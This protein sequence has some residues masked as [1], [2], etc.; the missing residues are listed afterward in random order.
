M[1]KRIASITASVT[2]SLLASIVALTVTPTAEAQCRPGSWL[3]AQAQVQV[4]V[5][6]SGSVYIGPTVVPPPP[7]P[8]VVYIQP[9]QPQPPVVIYQP[10]PQPQVVYQPQPQ[11]V[12]VQQQPQVSLQ[13]LPP[14]Q[15]REPRWGVHGELGAMMSNRISMGGGAVAFRMRPSPWFAVDLGIGTYG[16]IDYD[17]N[18]RFEI[19]IT[20]NALF[21][22]NPQSR[23]QLYFLAGVGLSYAHVD[24][25]GFTGSSGFGGD[26]FGR[27]FSYAGGQL[28]IGLEWRLGRHFALNTDLRGF[29]RTR[30][31]DSSTPE[32]VDPATG[33]TTNTSGGVYWTG[34]ATIYW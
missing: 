34:G 12:Y 19:P 23:L 29:I 17:G 28:G 16:G 24:S 7:P 5:G 31:D 27:D 11:V 13:P 4:G 8:Q 22:V 26:F 33:A 25:L 14:V 1:S 3:C 30:T 20:A 21:F 2:L 6:V 10:Q 32:F 18:D 9:Q 15:L